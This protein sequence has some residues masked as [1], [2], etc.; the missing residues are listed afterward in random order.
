[1]AVDGH[2]FARLSVMAA[3]QA[4]SAPVALWVCPAHVVF[5]TS[6]RRVAL[7]S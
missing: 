4:F 5:A 6:G 1:M 3:V 2:L 7:A